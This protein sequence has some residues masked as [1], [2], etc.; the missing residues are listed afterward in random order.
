[1][2]I[3][4]QA[5]ISACILVATASVASAQSASPC[6][7]LSGAEKRQCEERVWNSGCALGRRAPVVGGLC[8]LD[9]GQAPSL[10][11]PPLPQMPGIRRYPPNGNR[12]AD[13]DF[14]QSQPREWPRSDPPPRGG[15]L[16]R[17]GRGDD[18]SRN[19]DRS[20]DRPYEPPGPPPLPSAVPQGFPQ[21][22]G[23]ASPPPPRSQSG[24]FAGPPPNGRVARAC[25]PPPIL[26]ERRGHSDAE[27]RRLYDRLVTQIC[28]GGRVAMQ[29]CDSQTGMCWRIQP[30]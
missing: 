12:P 11:P 21:G 8:A 17:S 22:R 13:R 29:G 14:E 4:L 16:G 6:R 23:F 25:D 10:D 18:F 28:T 5:V 3:V 15:R 30:H 27:G 7:H 1:M 24:R 20:W 26:I 9:R 19:D 2:R